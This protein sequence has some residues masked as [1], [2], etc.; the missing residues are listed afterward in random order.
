MTPEYKREALWHPIGIRLTDRMFSA[1]SCTLQNILHISSRMKKMM[2]FFLLTSFA[3]TK[4]KIPVTCYEC[5]MT[6]ANG[7]PAATQYPCTAN[8]KQWQK[9]QKDNNGDPITS[10]CKAL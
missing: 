2:I 3:C 4:K 7:L 10:T 6:Y 8:I 9:A 5:E 1:E